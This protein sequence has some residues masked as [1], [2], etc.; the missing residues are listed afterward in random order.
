MPLFS[1]R[2]RQQS[3]S[4]NQQLPDPYPSSAPSRP[5][6]VRPR[7]LVCDDNSSVVDL[8][9]LTFDVHGWD[10]CATQTGEE[11]LAQIDSYAPDVVLVDQQMGGGL[12]GIETA[13]VLRARGYDLP[14]LLFSAYLD[15]NARA[16]AEML[17]VLAVSKVDFPAVVRH[18]TNAHT[19]AGRT[20]SHLV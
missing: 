14:V 15:E 3:R 7:L 1:R 9:K 11:G 19:Q 20:S 5:A 10:V 17:D 8:L 16:A 2:G 12:T 4:G 18:V 13:M 6:A